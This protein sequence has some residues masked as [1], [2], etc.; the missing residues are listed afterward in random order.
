M[1]TTI[2]F[3]GFYN[4]LHDCALDDA[5]EY[6]FADQDGCSYNHKLARR[7]Y[8]GCNWRGVR[9]AYAKDY[10]ESFAHEFGIELTFDSLD[11]PRFYNFTTDRIFCNLPINEAERLLDELPY[12]ALD[13]VAKDQFTSRDGFSS[14][15]SPKVEDWGDLSTWDH[16]QLGALVQAYVYSKDDSLG[17]GEF[18]DYAEFALMED[19]RGN[20]CID[21]WIDDNTP[22][23]GRL[24][25]VWNYLNE[26]AMRA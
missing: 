3:S 6:M 14:F 21:S 16:N 2:P 13:D 9:E 8:D 12:G 15:Y 10:A 1:L 18:D 19:A 22:Q 25:K 24:Y 5:V 17:D 4:S 20:G 26:R 7:V 11:S 23:L